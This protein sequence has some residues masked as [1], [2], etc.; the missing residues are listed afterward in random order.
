VA[1]DA[2]VGGVNSNSYVTR[3]EFDAYFLAHLDSS[4]W[5]GASDAEIETALIQATIELDLRTAYI[6][7]KATTTQALEWPRID[8]D[9][10]TV[11]TSVIPVN[12]KYA[13]IEL[14]SSLLL[15]SASGSSSS[16]SVTQPVSSLKIGSS[17]EVKYDT[18][19][20]AI[21]DT[22]IDIAGVAIDS[23]RF[24]RGLRIPAILA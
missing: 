21:V 18:S 12:L 13:Q 3:D 2:S 17:V 22:S 9:I 8:N 23:S 20:G 5:D 15:A 14:A 7:D 16:S 10:F 24:L 6:G 11:P 4:A 19:S 1:I